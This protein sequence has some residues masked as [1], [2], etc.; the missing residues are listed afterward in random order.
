MKKILSLLLAAMMLLSLAACSGG[1]KTAEATQEPT[2]AP[3]EEPVNFI[4]TTEWVNI[5]TSFKLSFYADNKMKLNKST[6]TWA[7]DEDGVITINYTGS[8]DGKEYERTIDIVEEDGYKVLIMREKREPNSY[9]GTDIFPQANYY[10]V[11]SAEEVKASLTKNMGESVSTDILELTMVSAEF[12]TGAS[13]AHSTW[14]DPHQPSVG[15]FKVGKG[16]SLVA[17]TFKVKNLD[18]D[19]IN[20]AG[21]T[22]THWFLNWRLIYQDDYYG[23]QSF[24]LNTTFNGGASISLGEAAISYDGI[25]FSKYASSNMLLGT[26]KTVY[27]RVIGVVLM[28]PENIS[29]GFDL[30]VNLINSNGDNEN[31]FINVK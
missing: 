28:E 15:Y 17:L 30:V 3:T 6:G 18:R 14:A 7:Q 31:F 29:D 21:G 13:S 11:D 23:I 26:G 4:T 10:P 9:G 5:L 22:G 12:C 25:S 16:K 1:G 19:T 20:I 27:I 2:E 24:A 8:S